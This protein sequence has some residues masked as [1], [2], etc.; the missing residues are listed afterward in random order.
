MQNG[1]GWKATC[2]H[3]PIRP[4]D[5]ILRHAVRMPQNGAVLR[6]RPLRATLRLISSIA[7]CMPMAWDDEEE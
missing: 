7:S 2:R 3:Q 1:S 6:T 4:G 5:A